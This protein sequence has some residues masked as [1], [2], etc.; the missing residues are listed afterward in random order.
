MN[1]GESHIVNDEELVRFINDQEVFILYLMVKYFI[2]CSK[3]LLKI[4]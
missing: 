3:I 1:S 4:H 2:G